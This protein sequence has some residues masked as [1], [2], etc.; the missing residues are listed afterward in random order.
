M[1]S[2]LLSRVKIENIT[3]Y[4]LYG[5][6][7]EEIINIG[8]NEGTY[9]SKLNSAYEEF[10]KELKLQYPS[11]DEDTVYSL[12]NNLLTI[13]DEVYMEIGLIAGTQLN[14]QLIKDN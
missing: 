9:E 8:S 12:V 7:E 5:S 4:I 3:R 2:K 1:L 10:Y 6:A 14:A 13:H 11:V